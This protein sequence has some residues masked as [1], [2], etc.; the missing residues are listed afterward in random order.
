MLRFASRGLDGALAPPDRILFVSNSNLSSNN[1]ISF[2]Y[3][4]KKS[5]FTKKYLFFHYFYFLS[6]FHLLHHL[7]FCIK[8]KN[9]HFILFMNWIFHYTNMHLFFLTLSSI[10]SLKII[11]SICL[12]SS[13]LLS[14]KLS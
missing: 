12:I 13:S 7:C 1:E 2:L 3:P 9:I 14:N 11:I 6:S 4:Y 8:N 10:F 5:T